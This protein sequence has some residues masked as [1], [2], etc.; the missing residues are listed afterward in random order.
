MVSLSDDDIEFAYFLSQR[1]V[2]KKLKLID[3]KSFPRF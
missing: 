1:E 3:R 2:R